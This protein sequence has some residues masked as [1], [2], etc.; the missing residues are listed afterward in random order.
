MVPPADPDAL[1]PAELKAL[2]SALLGKVAEL[3]RRVAAQREEIA[4]LKGLKGRPVIKPSGME[5]AT[6]P[7]PP[8]AG[9]GRRRRGKV[10]PRVSVE[11]RVLHAT[12]PPGSQFR[13]YQDFLVQDLV[14]RTEA[15]RYRRERWLTPEG[16]LVVA[17]LPGG[18]EGHFGPEL[19]RY[20]LAQYHQGQ[21]TVLRL[22]AQLRAVGIAISKR[23]VMRL[24]IGDQRRFLDEHRDVLRAGLASAAW[25]TVD[26]T[27]ARH[28]AVNGAC[29]Q[30]GNDHFA[31]FGTT[32]SKSRLNFLELLR[33]GHG[34][35]AVNAEALAYMR[36]RA[37]AG[38]VIARLAGDP[39]RVFPDQAAWVAHLERLGIRG[40][41]GSLG[42]A[43]L[44]TEGA[45]WGAIKAHDLLS[46]TVIVSDDAGQFALGEHA[47]CWIH[48]ERL[49]HRLETFTDQQRAVQARIR[50][51]IWWFYA[52][53]KAYR[54][55]PSRR[56]RVEL[57]ARFDRIFQ[58][59]T[60][61]AMLDRL[62]ERLHAN[63]AELL[64]VLDRPEIPLHTNGS[65]NDIR[66]QVTRRKLSGGTR[67]DPGRDCRDA[68]LGLAKTCAKLGLSFWDYLGARL[69]IP[70]QASIPYLPDLVR[71][72]CQ[73]A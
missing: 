13:G 32:A 64:Q 17:P 26:D 2:V 15:V 19:R 30:I 4:R 42:P 33:A 43:R 57:R 56:R 36:E 39:Q 48:A 7:K 66:A 35:Y 16:Q 24:L 27:G 38:P 44:A 11:E 53:L 10:M 29:T 31:W 61:F 37:L 28:R 69:G 25:I 70:G 3:E 54:R 55:E 50:D 18:V 6:E 8:Q 68:F 40:M 34:D 60:G 20:V 65:E 71:Q 52:D 9:K 1:S 21:A 63:K 51:L 49:V 14:L 58:R 45:L 73:P 12:V 62:L 23:Q 5:R 67:S 47:L 46:G 41:D 22:V 72:R 59:R